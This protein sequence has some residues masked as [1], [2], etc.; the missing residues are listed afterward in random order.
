MTYL[1]AYVYRRLA[2]LLMCSRTPSGL[3]LDTPL[4]RVRSTSYYLIQILLSIFVIWQNNE[5]AEGAVMLPSKITAQ[6][7]VIVVKGLR[8]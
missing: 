5:E 6:S 2:W 1:R 8:V 3:L 7:Q 4:K